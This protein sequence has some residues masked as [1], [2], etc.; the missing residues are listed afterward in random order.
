MTILLY[1]QEVSKKYLIPRNITVVET[2][3]KHE[4]GL[5]LRRPEAA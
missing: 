3:A 4:L 5:R 2:R 1:P